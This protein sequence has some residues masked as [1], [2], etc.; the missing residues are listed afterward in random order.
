MIDLADEAAA[1][2]ANLEG[3]NKMCD[4]LDTFN[5]A[6]ASYL[7]AMR[8]NAFCVEWHQ[9]CLLTG[10]KQPEVANDDYRLRETNRSGLRCAKVPSA[11]YIVCPDAHTL[12]HVAERV[13]ETAAL[14]SSRE[15][16]PHLGD[17]A[18][19]QSNIGDA[20]VAAD[21][22]FSRVHA[23]DDNTLQN[24]TEQQVQQHQQMNAKPKAKAGP[25][26]MTAKERKERS[27]GVFYL[28]A[29]NIVLK[30][31]FSKAKIESV[32]DALP[33][34]FRGQDPVCS[35]DFFQPPNLILIQCRT[36]VELSKQL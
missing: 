3:L 14:L 4:A 33:L 30:A 13:K 15:A 29:H 34:E 21:Q 24:E 16:T 36:F 27:V 28:D 26:K 5:E 10:T 12:P 11:P 2:H 1:L 35:S 17:H 32:V 7:Y 19:A 20:S 25:K 6:F 23:G 8:M 9:V 18:T 22:T 31:F